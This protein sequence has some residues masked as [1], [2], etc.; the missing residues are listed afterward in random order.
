L[1]S[2]TEIRYIDA[3]KLETPNFNFIINFKN[4]KYIFDVMFKKVFQSLKYTL[5]LKM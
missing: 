1:Q 3:E 4:V 5:H 2:K